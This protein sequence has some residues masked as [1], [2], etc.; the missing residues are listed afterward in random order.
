MLGRQCQHY[1]VL[2]SCDTF[3]TSCVYTA[4]CICVSHIYHFTC[5]YCALARVCVNHCELA[6][7]ACSGP[8]PLIV[9]EGGRKWPELLPPL[10]CDE[11]I[12][13]GGQRERPAD[14]EGM[15]LN[16][17]HRRGGDPWERRELVTSHLASTR[18]GD[19][20]RGSLEWTCTY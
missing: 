15:E 11:W 4:C 17:E 14:R 18:R 1:Y 10:V 5:I 7:K 3:I 16:G 13:D 20:A 8:A 12:D 19:E 6:K 9:A 2:C